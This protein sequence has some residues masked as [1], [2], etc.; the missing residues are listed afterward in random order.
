MATPDI[1]NREDGLF[2]SSPLLEPRNG[3]SVKSRGMSIEKKIEF[4]ESLAGTV[5]NRRSRR[6]INDRLLMELVPRLNAEEIRGLFAPPPWGDDVPLSPF[7]MTNV[8]EWDTFRN[9]DMDKQANIIGS[10]ISPC[11]KNKGPVDADKM[12]VLNAWRRID[13]RTRQAL[14]RSVV[15]ELI[16]CYEERIRAF[17]RETEDGDGLILQVQDPFRRLLLHGV[18]EFYNLVSVTVTESE[19]GEAI[20]VTKITKK[21]GRSIELPN[22]TLSHF[23]KMSKQGMWLGQGAKNRICSGPTI[24]ADDVTLF[25][26]AVFCCIIKF[27]SSMAKKPVKYSVVDAFTESAFKGNPAA[28]CLLEEDKDDQWLQAVASEFNLSQSCYLTR[29]TDST[30]TS[31]PRFG[32][33]WFTPSNEVE[34]C[35][36]ATLAAAYTL[37]E[38]GLINSNFIEFATLSGILTAKKVPD[39]K[40]ANG[41]NNIQNGEAQN[42]Y[43]IELNLPA[44]PSYE[45]NSSEVSL[46]SEALD[47]ASMIDIRK[48]HV[49]DDLLVVLPSAKAVVDLQPKFD[50]IQ[51]CPGSGGV[52]VTGIAPPESEYD[53]YS[54]YFCPKHGIDDDPVCG[55]AHC[56]LASYWCKKL[57]KSDVFAYAA[58][59]RGGAVSVHLD[60]QNQR[61]LL[62]GKAVTV[63]EGTVLV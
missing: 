12:A 38:S 62:R 26:S 33:R 15:S 20:K 23:L 61:V 35:G 52:I 13:S 55:S 46:I 16:E 10:S 44:A 11:A 57:G 4:L 3:E 6:W 56:A 32:L 36:H 51:K 60:E 17:V 19:N 25:A 39:V 54:R 21:K 47:G 27:Q 18:C 5:S 53:F 24:I 41:A 31:A 1:L 30:P 8:R 14:R 28:V 49:T 58:S 22:I 29:V 40:T 9:I 34:L 7:C 45:F 43:F 37:F 48:T 42:S 59:R 50:A 2:L 63:M